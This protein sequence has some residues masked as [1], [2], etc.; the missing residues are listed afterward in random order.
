MTK[1]TVP[2]ASA[3]EEK[4]LV[5]FFIAAAIFLELEFGGD[6]KSSFLTG[7]EGVDWMVDEDAS[8]LLCFLFC[9]FGVFFG[10]SKKDWLQPELLS[11]EGLSLESLSVL[12]FSPILCAL[13]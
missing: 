3:R 13:P 2:S 10:V 6:E 5:V 9:I 4:S 12:S 1:S 11:L 8:F 7:H